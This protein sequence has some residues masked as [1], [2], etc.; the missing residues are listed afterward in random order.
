MMFFVGNNDFFAQDDDFNKIMTHMPS[1]TQVVR[2]DDYNHLD[3]M[4]G[5]DANGYVNSLAIKFI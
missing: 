4:W 1:S 3:Y 5:A 2:V